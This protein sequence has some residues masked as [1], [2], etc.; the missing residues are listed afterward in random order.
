MLTMEFTY[1]SL[2]LE[3]L[4]QIEQLQQLVVKQLAD[5]TI[6]QPLSQEE[7]INILTGNGEMLGA[8]VDDV[9]VAC[10]ALLRPEVDEEEHLGVDAKATDLSRVIYQEVSFV[11][12]SYR[13]HGLQKKLGQRLMENLSLQEYDVVCSTVK[14]F[15][16]P[17]LKDK[18]SQGLMVVALKLK[19]GGKLRYVFAKY[20]NE[21][22][23]FTGIKKSV[24][25]ANTA[26]QQ[27]LLDEGYYGTTLYEEQGVWYITYEK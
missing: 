18:F 21:P 12:P 6:L 13:G 7:L 2:T 11:N 24:E 4:S 22:V 3:D 26:L 27:E 9:L 17:S 25:M 1:K 14:P 15:N 10:R 16:I 8:Y 20:L 19:Y 23:T 5:S